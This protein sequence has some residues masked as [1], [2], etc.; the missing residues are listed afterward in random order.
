M[1]MLLSS[2]F[3]L[4]RLGIATNQAIIVTPHVSPKVLYKAEVTKENLT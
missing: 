1:V 4:V 2:D 3:F